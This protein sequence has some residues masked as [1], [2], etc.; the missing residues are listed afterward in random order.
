MRVSTGGYYV[1]RQR[2]SKPPCPRRRKVRDLTKNCF[3]EN[4]RRYG[5]RRIAAV[6][7]RAGEKIGRFQ[8]RGVLRQ[9]NLQAI[10]PKRFVPRT[11][12]SGHGKLASPK[13]LAAKKTNRGSGSSDHRRYYLS[14]AL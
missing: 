5:S 7:Q 2:L 1:W 4:R 8:V 6:L 13:L 3:W 12:D 10:R 9:E 11:T 14:A